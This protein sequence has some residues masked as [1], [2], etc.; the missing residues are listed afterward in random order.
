MT[1][2]GFRSQDAFVMRAA[3]PAQAAAPSRPP[4]C[5]RR[6]PQERRRVSPSTYSIDRK[7]S[8]GLADVVD[9]ADVGWTSRAHLGNAHRVAR[10]AEELSE[11][12][13]TSRRRGRPHPAPAESR[14]YA[15]HTGWN[16]VD[17]G[18]LAATGGTIHARMIAGSKPLILQED[19]GWKRLERWCEDFRQPGSVADGQKVKLC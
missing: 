9:A 2:A 17:P 1:L 8:V 14:T 13:E 4:V 19:R 5:G 18:D 15:A 7:V 10:L 11:A 16:A 12:G 6:R 3:R